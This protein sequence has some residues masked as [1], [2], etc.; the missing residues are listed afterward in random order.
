MDDDVGDNDPTVADVIDE[1]PE[2]VQILEK[3]RKSGTWK[4]MG[5]G[6]PIFF[7]ML[8]LLVFYAF[9]TCTTNKCYYNN[10]TTNYDKNNKYN[11]KNIKM[12]NDHNQVQSYLPTFIYTFV[13]NSTSMVKLSI[14][15]F[16]IFECCHFI[17]NVLVIK[18]TCSEIVETTLIV[19]DSRINRTLLIREQ[20]TTN[21]ECLF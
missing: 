16:C 1:R 4:V 14:S 10:N 5:D 8:N 17:H 11:K 7:C 12:N 18:G 2:S 20:N 19:K 21:C 6:E 9:C 15:V 13:M 3:Y